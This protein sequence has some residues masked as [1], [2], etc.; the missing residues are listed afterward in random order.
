VLKQRVDLAE[1]CVAE[2]KEDLANAKTALDELASNP[3]GGGT[4]T[5]A[6]R[7]EEAS[8]G[9]VERSQHLG[10]ARERLRDTQTMHDQH[11]LEYE[12][13]ALWQFSGGVTG[14]AAIGAAG[15]TLTGFGPS[16]IYR[17]SARLELDAVF[18][19][20][21]LENDLGVPSLRGLIG[22]TSGN[23]GFL[24]GIGASKA[25]TNDTYSEQLA[26]VFPLAI[27]YRFGSELR[28]TSLIPVLDLA[29][30]A[31]PWIVGTSDGPFEESAVLFG[32]SATLG[33]GGVR[34]GSVSGLRRSEAVTERCKPR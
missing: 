21:H 3:G 31:E 1:Y 13:A 12:R 33:L 2:A 19:Y 15:R 24:G 30:M 34:A 16:I 28:C 5:T 9:V 32:V 11:Q 10:S 27:R 26:L 4:A 25:E 20:D 23:W 14:Y 18:R 7:L 22:L 29:L 6:A 17:P 8:R